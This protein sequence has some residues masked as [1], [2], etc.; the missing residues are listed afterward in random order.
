VDRDRLLIKMITEFLVNKVYAQVTGPL[1]SGDG[2]SITLNNPLGASNGTIVGLINTVISYFTLYIAPAVVVIMVLYGA[3]QML[4]AGGKPEEFA[5][6][7]KTILYAIIGYAIVLVAAGLV[8]V[9]ETVI[10]GNNATLF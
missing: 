8:A 3:F 7:R 4:T 1:S 10:G 6:G 9:V 2:G 5:K